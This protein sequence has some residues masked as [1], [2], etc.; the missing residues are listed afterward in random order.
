MGDSCDFGI[1]HEHPSGGVKHRDYS[2]SE[3]YYAHSAEPLH[4][5]APYVYAVAHMCDVEQYA[6]TGGGE[7]RHSLEKGVA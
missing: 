1:E 7:S 6:C 5:G 3:Q 2:Q 4:G